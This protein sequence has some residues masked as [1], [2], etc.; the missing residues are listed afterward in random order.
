[1]S[2]PGDQADWE[3]EGSHTSQAPLGFSVPVV[4]Q[5]LSIKQQLAPQQIA[6]ARSLTSSAIASEQ[7]QSKEPARVTM[8]SPS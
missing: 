1:M 3:R 7:N 2:Q 5:V 8:A 6:C 4:R